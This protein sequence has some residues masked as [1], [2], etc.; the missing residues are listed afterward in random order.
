MHFGV[1][2]DTFG[3]QLLIQHIGFGF[4]LAILAKRDGRNCWNWF[5]ACLFFGVLGLG[6]YFFSLES[7]S[8]INNSTAETKY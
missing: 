3:L 7:R 8:R 2:M 1:D 6:W 4:V 5:L